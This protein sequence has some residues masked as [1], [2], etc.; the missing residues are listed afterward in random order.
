MTQHAV[1]TAPRRRGSSVRA[2]V[3][4]KQWEQG[5]PR[6]VLLVDVLAVLLATF[7]SAELRFGGFAL[8]QI[9]G[10]EFLDYGL[11]SLVLS[12]AWV[13]ALGVDG[14][15]DIRI[16]G[17][18]AEEYKRVL[19]ATLHLFGLV[20]I[21]AY[22]ATFEVAR[23]YV[24]LALP[25][26]ILLIMLGRFMVRGWLAR[27]RHR[28]DFRRRLLLVG[29]PK[30]V[31][32]IHGALEPE[33]GA[34]YAPVA[35]VLPGYRPREEE[36][37]PVP[38]STDVE[39]VQ[40]LIAHV[41]RMN[42]EAVAI[43]SG[44][45]FVPEEVRHLGWDLQ[46][47]GVSLIM[48]P[49]LVD[50]AGPRLHTQPLAGLPLLHLSTPRLSSSKASLKRAFDL[51]SAG[52]GIVLISPLLLAVAIAVKTTSPGPV[53]FRQ[54]RIGLHGEP[55]TMLKFRSMVVDAEEIKAQLVSDRGEDDILFKMKD[56]PRVTRVGSFIRRT[57]IDELP[58]LVNVLRGD[59]SLV[60]PR[61]HLPHEVA[62]YGEYVHRR[63][64]VQPGIT[65][66]WQVS[67]RS[68]LSWEDAVR[69]DLYYV[70]NWSLLGDLVILGRT[71]KAVAASDGA[72]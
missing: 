22:A 20:A 46:E 41:D 16:L 71:V 61:P 7:L 5:L 1:T 62:Q 30:A 10:L 11:L 21:F 54:E 52:I 38:V 6:L 27:R 64:L 12:A 47:R 50:V 24:G 45:P 65:G 66:L 32:H 33:A 19:R 57:S 42:I 51:V 60:G 55:F 2:R 3:L 53:L 36:W 68:D 26:G 40:E 31:Q 58:Q 44:H 72:Y 18:G 9:P 17:V 8:A 23:G 28:G 69:L 34:G 15:R 29:G 48:A 59:M 14:S 49:A 35:A 70:E 4:G 56:D 13:A 39:T 67:G 43:T 63:F 25:L 37:L